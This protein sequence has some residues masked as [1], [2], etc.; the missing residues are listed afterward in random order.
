MT[1]YFIPTR[2]AIIKTKMGNNVGENVEK[3][4]HLYIPGVNAKWQLVLKT[5]S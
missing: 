3:L 5:V 1:Y 2:T 4:Q